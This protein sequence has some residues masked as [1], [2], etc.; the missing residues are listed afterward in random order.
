MNKKGVRSAKY[1]RY[2]LIILV[3]GLAFLTFITNPSITGYIT[4]QYNSQEYN[5]TFESSEGYTYDNDLIEITNNQAQLKKIDLD[6]SNYLIAEYRLDRNKWEDPG[7]VIDSSDNEFHGTAMGDAETDTQGIIIRKG[8][9]DGDG[10]YIQIERDDRPEL[11][12]ADAITIMAWVKNTA[13]NNNYMSNIICRSGG[14]AGCTYRLYLND[15]SSN[16]KLGI[17]VR[18]ENGA[19][20][21]EWAWDSMDEEWFHFAMTFS[22]DNGGT[23]TLYLNGQNITQYSG[24]GTTLTYR[25][26]YA[27]DDLYLG[28]DWNGN[29]FHGFLDEVAVYHQTLSPIEIQTIYE[30][31]NN[32]NRNYKIYP[33]S[34]ILQ[35]EALAITNP[36][37]IADFT[38]QHTN[39]I[40]FS[41]SN[42]GQIWNLIQ[43]NQ[44]NLTNF[45]QLQIQANF[46]SDGFLQPTLD[47]MTLSYTT[48]TCTENWTCGNWTPAACPENA[49]QTRICTDS[50]EC[51]T[52]ITLPNLTQLCQYLAPSVP[53]SNGGGSSRTH[54]APV[55]VA[56]ILTTQTLETNLPLKTQ[57]LPSSEETTTSFNCDYSLEL[58]LPKEISLVEQNSFQGKITNQG[59]CLIQRLNLYLS[60]ELEPLIE[61]PTYFENLQQGNHT[62]FTLIRKTENKKKSLFG[63]ITGSAITAATTTETVTGAIILEGQNEKET[64]FTQ[65]LSLQ[66]IIPGTKKIANKLG[67]SL[68][69][70]GLTLLSFVLVFYKRKKLNKKINK[71]KKK[72]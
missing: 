17:Q 6:L 14:S 7:D 31:Q 28:S 70:A 62:L 18:T 23:M 41:Q 26:Q 5:W 68:W 65:E 29:Y 46:T 20:S 61:L 49:T 40:Y 21:Q 71:K 36:Y 27:G 32:N 51:D 10:D 47:L 55:S 64:I 24:L 63:F 37:E 1:L 25:T 15:G 35:T 43:N 56:P 54:S 69:I 33:S 38:T 50:N 12:P 67:I 48:Q 57:T 9:F 30:Y 58:T 16:D 4:Y 60:P 3:V 59:N 2:S 52:T 22:S 19:Q 13:R 34:A 45:T 11:D 39:N 8:S 53:V 42:D 44:L 66:L 72:H